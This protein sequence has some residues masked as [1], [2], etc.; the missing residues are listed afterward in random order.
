MSKIAFENLN[1]LDAVLSVHADLHL[2]LMF[3]FRYLVCAVNQL[4]GE[5]GEGEENRL[6]N[7]KKLRKHQDSYR[8]WN[9]LRTDIKPLDE[10][11]V[12]KC[13]LYESKALLR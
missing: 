4:A 11:W 9:K 1:G 8:M 6:S 5:M 3:F 7:T 13:Y 10:K 12:K 2:F